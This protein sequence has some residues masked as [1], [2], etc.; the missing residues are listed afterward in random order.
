L[1]NFLE[2]VSGFTIGDTSAGMTTPRAYA[3]LARTLSN[4]LGWSYCDGYLPYLQTVG[5]MRQAAD[6]LFQQVA[7]IYDQCP[8]CYSQPPSVPAVDDFND[9]AASMP[10]LRF[11]DGLARVCAIADPDKPGALSFMVAPR[12]LLQGCDAPASSQQHFLAGMYYEVDKKSQQR[13]LVTEGCPSLWEDPYADPAY[14]ADSSYLIRYTGLCA[15]DRLRNA[16]RLFCLIETGKEAYGKTGCTSPPIGKDMTQVSDV[17]SVPTP[18]PAAPPPPPPARAIRD[19]EQILPAPVYIPWCIVETHADGSDWKAA[20]TARVIAFATDIR[21]IKM[22][23]TP[24]D[25]FGNGIDG[26]YPEAVLFDNLKWG[27]AV[28]PQSGA[29]LKWLKLIN[30]GA[31]RDPKTNRLRWYRLKLSTDL[32]PW[33]IKPQALRCQPVGVDYTDQPP[34]RL[35]TPPPA[36]ASH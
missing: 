33:L 26:D 31:P 27:E 21:R 20:V 24:L 14:P 17:W 4:R 6:Y 23:I 3:D 5:C 32:P 36:K 15:T 22:K 16:R 10:Q 2:G 1:G 29:N 12:N 9:D 25:Y 34:W 11:P 13:V 35:T 30:H 8:R 28:E 19:L 18:M 7:Q